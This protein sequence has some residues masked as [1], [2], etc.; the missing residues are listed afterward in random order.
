MTAVPEP[1]GTVDHSEQ[2][3]RLDRRLR[4]LDQ[5]LADGD[6]LLA[7]AL[8]E[9]ASGALNHSR[10]RLG[11]GSAFTVVALAGAT[12]SGKSS[13]FNAVA[14][15]DIS[16]PGVTRPTTSEVVAASFGGSANEL[17][18]WLEV[19]RRHVVDNE[20]LAGLVLLDL[21]DHDSTAVA[22]R[23][24]VD[25]LVAVTDVFA[26]VV[27]PQKYADAVLHDDYLKRFSGH[28]AVTL[29]ILN[30]IDRLDP[31]ERRQ[32]VTHLTSL[33]EQDGLSGVRVLQTSAMS[34]EGIPPLRRELAARVAERRAVITRLEA[35][36]DWVS[37]DLV[38]ACGDVSPDG[39]PPAHAAR[40]AE[41]LAHAAGVD[42][43]AAAVGAAHQHRATAFVGWP[44]TRWVRKLRADPLHTLGL[45]R[46][47]G[48][49][50][51]G[52]TTVGGGN[53]E[54]APVGRT[55][56]PTGGVVTEAAATMAVKEIIRDATEGI[57]EPLRSNISDRCQ[58]S[59]PDLTDAL[60]TAIS[61]TRLPVTEPRWWHTV[62]AVQWGLCLV[63]VVGLVWLA[64]IG[65]VSWMGLPDLPSPKIGK[66]PLPTILAVGGAVLGLALAAIARA[67][68]GVGAARRESKARAHLVA[69]TDEVSQQLVVEPLNA[70]LATVRRLSDHAR[71]F[72]R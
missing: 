33:L 9:R 2:L 4:Q 40:L 68:V 32:C 59:T 17:L 51:T 34:S 30:Q 14:G 31:D 10:E 21:P 66:L 7:P 37:S 50:R 42:A 72:A 29:V 22:H 6:G 11:H 16:Q 63:M 70:Q 26:W 3:E 20:Q 18:D 53:D 12:G 54:L 71:E 62:S 19:R 56:R 28:G 23:M 36:L 61:R 47:G 48:H 13:L 69:R 1:I 64:V 39:V 8:I 43:V 5:L 15:S 57:P 60:D 38:A 44:P 45:G 67:A 24:E 46:S 35:D 52:A 49:E 65:V 41:T 27:D 25:R 55:S 58:V